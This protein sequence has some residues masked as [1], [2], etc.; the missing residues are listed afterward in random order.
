VTGRNRTATGSKREHGAL[1]TKSITEKRKQG[2]LKALSVATTSLFLNT[3]LPES[4]LKM[5]TFRSSEMLVSTCHEAGSFL[6]SLQL[7]S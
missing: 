5:E 6:R 7:F 1:A 2:D 4:T 3:K